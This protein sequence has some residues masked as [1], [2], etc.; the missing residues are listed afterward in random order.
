MYIRQHR[1]IRFITPTVNFY[2]ADAVDF[3]ECRII[4]YFCRT[5]DKRERRNQREE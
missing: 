2:S 4:F 1:R 3:T 5:T